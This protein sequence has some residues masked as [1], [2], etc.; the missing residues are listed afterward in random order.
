MIA[1][2]AKAVVLT[3]GDSHLECMSRQEIAEVTK[4]TCEHV[5]GRA[6][7]VAADSFYATSH[8]IE[9]AE[10]ARGCGADVIMV[11]PPNWAQ[12]CTPKTMAE[13]YAA[14][15]EHL[16]VMIVTNI[17]I[18]LGVDFGL[19]T[20]GRALDLSE[21]IVSVK[22]DMCGDFARRLCLLAHER[23]AVWAGGCKVNHMNMWPYGCNGYLSSF[24]LFK[25]DIAWKYWHAIEA[26]DMVA[27]RDVIRDFDNPFFDF[28][29][30]LGDWNAAMHGTLEL[31][32]VC[33]RW[34]RK[35]Y[36]S[37]NDEEMDRL[38]VFLC[39]KGLLNE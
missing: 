19:E 29:D 6:T 35:P 5:A 32:G 23:C 28:L 13:H 36:Y 14:V 21:D 24:M 8:S 7:V 18:P 31:F 26:N 38:A 20:I 34:R 37:L 16:P 22:D 4:V 30:K 10:Y 17:F 27:A 2:N 15:A 39:G 3:D 12:S 11:L 33:K 25:P 1:A 9:F